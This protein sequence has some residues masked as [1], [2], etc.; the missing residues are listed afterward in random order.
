M[1]AE[2]DKRYTLTQPQGEFLKGHLLRYMEADA[3]GNADADTEVVVSA[4]YEEFIT[5]FNISRPDERKIKHVGNRQ[6]KYLSYDNHFY[7][8]LDRWFT[9]KTMRAL[10]K[11]RVSKPLRTTGREEFNRANFKTRIRPKVIKVLKCDDSRHRYWISTVQRVQAYLWHRL[12]IEEKNYYEK[13]ARERNEG[14][15]SVE[16]KAV[17]V[18]MKLPSHLLLDFHDSFPARYADKYFHTRFKKVLND[19]ATAYGVRVIAV[20]VRQNGA[21]VEMVAVYVLILSPIADQQTETTFRHEDDQGPSYMK[22]KHPTRPHSLNWKA[23]EA[24][25][26]YGRQILPEDDSSKEIPKVAKNEEDYELIWVNGEPM[27]PPA[28]THSSAHNWKK[29]LGQLLRLA[30]GTYLKFPLISLDVINHIFQG[31]LTGSN[32]S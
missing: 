17:Y 29:L 5:H 15:V 28:S 21:G 13:L 12:P 25:Q 22:E 18:T 6:I 14:K 4:V 30:W 3:R 8:A 16:Q 19:A 27:L 24:A 9:Y 31:K 20:T 10:K 23:A 11:T 1:A 2:P 32:G 7:Q 26:W